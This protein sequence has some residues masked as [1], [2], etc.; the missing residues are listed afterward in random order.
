MTAPYATVEG[1]P[2]QSVRL[3]VAASGPW[4]ADV[5]L[6]G[7][8]A[9]SGRV[10]LA[11]GATTL[12]GTILTRETGAHMERRRMRIV[13]GAGAW[14]TLLPA[15]PYH[16]DSGVRALLV[17]Q[18]AAR[19]AGESLG[20]DFAPSVDRIGIDYVRTAGAAARVLEDVIGTA[21]WWV[22]YAG[23]TRVGARPTAAARTGAYVV[24]EYDPRERVVDLTLDEDAL[25]LV[26]IGTILSEGLEDPQTVRE[27]DVHVA[28]EGV[29]LRAW[30]GGQTSARGQLLDAVRAIVD[31]AT[32]RKL[33]GLWRYRVIRMSGNPE[34]PTGPR[35]H[36]QSIRRDIGLP[37]IEPISMWP[38]V[39]G[40]HARLRNSTEVLVQF[41]EGDRTRPVITHF[42]GNDGQLWDP[43]ELIFEAALGKLGVNAATGV[44]KEDLVEGQLQRLRDAIANA[45]TGASDGGATFKANI[46]AALNVPPVFPENVGSSKWKVE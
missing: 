31:R 14:G 27:L 6:E 41:V 10:D 28:P 36:L 43:R 45:A 16:S 40:A 15:K 2:A 19:E 13:A 44:A 11:L 24:A 39:P 33:F 3:H 8:P 38:G 37:D 34:A 25:S 42:V 23:V 22:D 30:C 1:E 17:A 21:A 18:D 26:G 32:D 7:A 12:S 35:V 29:R 4:F 46:I 20:D 9:L 5:E